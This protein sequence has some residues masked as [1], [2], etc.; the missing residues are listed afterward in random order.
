M[1]KWAEMEE[2]ADEIDDIAGNRKDHVCVIVSVL[3]F[4][5]HRGVTQGAV[6][7]DWIANELEGRL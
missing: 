2:I 7:I 5:D 6:D 1:D 4:L 3:R